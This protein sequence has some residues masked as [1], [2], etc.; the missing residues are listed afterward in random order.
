MTRISIPLDD[1]NET[2]KSLEDIGERIN[3]TARLS[4]IGSKDEVGDAKLADSLS[5]FD[6]A[7]G[8]GHEKVQENVKVFSENTKKISDAFTQT[9]DETVKTLD[10]SKKT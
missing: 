6:G 2:V 7:W 3:K 4:D 5:D 8:R 10:E 1:L 9:D